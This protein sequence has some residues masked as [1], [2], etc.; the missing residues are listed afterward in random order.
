M[1]ASCI[2]EVRTI[3]SDFDGTLAETYFPLDKFMRE[4]VISFLSTKRNLFILTDER[5]KNMDHRLISLIPSELRQF[6]HIFSDGGSVGLGYTKDGTRFNYFNKS[7]SQCDEEAIRE[8]LDSVLG[9]DSYSSESEMSRY[10]IGAQIRPQCGKGWAEDSTSPCSLAKKLNEEIRGVGVNATLAHIGNGLFRFYPFSKEKVVRWVME[11][12]EFN[13]LR[14]KHCTEPIVVHE[15][16]SLII[17]DQ[18]GPYRNDNGLFLDFKGSIRVHVGNRDPELCIDEEGVLYAQ[19]HQKDALNVLVSPFIQTTA[20]VL[21]YLNENPD[22][23]DINR[24]EAIVSNGEVSTDKLKEIS[25]RTTALVDVFNFG[26]NYS[27]FWK[28]IH[29]I[30]K[31]SGRNYLEIIKDLENSNPN[32]RFPLLP[33]EEWIYVLPLAKRVYQNKATA[34]FFGRGTI[35]LSYLWKP[36]AILLESAGI[37]LPYSFEVIKTAS[38]EDVRS[39]NPLLVRVGSEIL[40]YKGIYTTAV[41]INSLLSDE[42]S[43]ESLSSSDIKRLIQEY[44][45]MQD[46]KDFD[47]E[48]KRER[49]YESLTEIISENPNI[50]RGELIHIIAD[51]GLDNRYIMFL[52]RFYA[53]PFYSL[54]SRCFQESIALTS[55]LWLEQVV[56]SQKSIPEELRMTKEEREAMLDSLMSLVDESGGIRLNSWED[57]WY[58]IQSSIDAYEKLNNLREIIS[59]SRNLSEPLLR[60]LLSNTGFYTRNRG[61]ALIGL[62]D[63]SL[64][65]RNSFLLKMIGSI[66]SPEV[67]HQV[68]V[69][70]SCKCYGQI[71]AVDF[72]VSKNTILYPEE[73]PEIYDRLYLFFQT[74]TSYPVLRYKELYYTVLRNR[75]IDTHNGVLVE[76][77]FRQLSSD[78]KTI[79]ADDF[80]RIFGKS[81]FRQDTPLDPAEELLIYYLRGG[82]DPVSSIVVEEYLPNSLIGEQ[83][84]LNLGRRVFTYK[85][86]TLQKYMAVLRCCED[87]NQGIFSRLRSAE[88][89]YRDYHTYKII[90]LFEK[91]RAEYEARQQRGLSALRNPYVK[92]YVVAYFKGDIGFDE[93]KE[94]VHGFL[95]AE[96]PVPLILTQV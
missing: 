66:V 80:N 36:L 90:D 32:Q 57:V 24:L 47:S 62:D 38:F 50:R 58:V 4:V 17:A 41:T 46:R 65:G 35:P 84:F 19:S 8:V 43:T 56:A 76:A 82:T 85:R 91:H 81:T 54:L 48:L 61:K 2:R 63:S 92:S 49:G 83:S 11:G 96:V 27:L 6:L 77:N 18:T 12:D 45:S 78:A 33:E 74:G 60:I 25:T 52:K 16:Q 21:S 59:S 79:S 7:F 29:E 75:D 53:I 73:E 15:A 13:A 40:D 55:Q 14:V 89:E 95:R 28:W 44:N 88:R 26:G 64:S 3:F 9:V 1:V 31:R 5:E 68:G 37:R 87:S 23:I 30:K 67:Q 69:L 42:E 20:R 34:T 70:S 94:N 10:R 71:E 51:I 93:L 39:I 72:V 86:G 22:E